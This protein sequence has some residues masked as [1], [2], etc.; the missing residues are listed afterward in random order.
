MVNLV[1]KLKRSNPDKRAFSSIAL[2]AGVIPIAPQAYNQYEQDS[3][4]C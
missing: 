3:Y 1:M 4:S 2:F